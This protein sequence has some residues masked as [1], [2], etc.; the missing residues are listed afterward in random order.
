MNIRKILFTSLLV[1]GLG[2]ACWLPRLHAGAAVEA[3]AAASAPVP[4]IIQKGF[5][6]WAKNRDASW[7]FDVWKLGG[8]L[9]RDNKPSALARYFARQDA[10][11]GAFKNYEVINTKGVSQNSAVIY[12]CINFD[13][14]AIYGRFMV[15]RTDKDWVVQDMDFSPKPEAMMPWLAFEGGSYDQ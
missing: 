9:E 11:V 15:Y 3:P 13:H 5:T 7:A 10:S 2:G 8:L 6:M 4:A 14:A 12:M 1:L